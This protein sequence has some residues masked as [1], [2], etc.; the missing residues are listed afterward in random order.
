VR[1]IV[2]DVVDHAPGICHSEAKAA[3]PK[4]LGFFS[5]PDPIPGFFTT[6]AFVQDGKMIASAH[7]SLCIPPALA[8]SLTP[9]HSDD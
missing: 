3:Q 8:I 4:N 9:E 5:S 6:A 7:P 2:R 1:W